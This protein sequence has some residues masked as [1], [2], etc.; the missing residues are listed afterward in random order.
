M[1][2][3]QG[4]GPLISRCVTSLTT[5]ARWSFILQLKYHTTATN[6]WST[7]RGHLSRRLYH[8]APPSS[9]TRQSYTVALPIAMVRHAMLSWSASLSAAVKA[10]GKEQ[11]ALKLPSQ[12]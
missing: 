10:E 7:P 11:H 9:T 6:P 12:R 4:Q 2:K 8:G 1:C 5:S 3:T